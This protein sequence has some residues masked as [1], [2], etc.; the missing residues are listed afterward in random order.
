M[1][2]FAEAGVTLPA[3]GTQIFTLL[4]IRTSRTPDVHTQPRQHWTKAERRNS[5]ARMVCMDSADSYHLPRRL[6][7]E[8]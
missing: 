1:A 4:T 2:G 7:G 3:L 6:E 8:N 5:A